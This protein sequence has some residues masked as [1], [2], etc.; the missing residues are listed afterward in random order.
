[1]RDIAILL[2]LNCR[3]FHNYQVTTSGKNRCSEVS[4]TMGSTQA[5]GK[6]A[7]TVARLA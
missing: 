6:H 1:M 7:K 4:F 3:R 2:I 5:A